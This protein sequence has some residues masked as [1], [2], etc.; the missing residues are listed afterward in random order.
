MATL[1]DG[2]VNLQRF[3]GLLASA[4]SATQQVGDHVKQA[5]QQFSRL[6]DEAEQEGGGLNDNLTEL[7]QTLERDEAEALSALGELLQAATDAQQAAG[8]AHDKVEQTATDLD[9]KAGT[10][11]TDL[12]QASGQLTSE[13]FQ[14]LGQLL[15]E[16]QQQID[17]ESNEEE[18]A[19]TELEG[20]VGTF[21]S[22]AET[23][24]N[25]AEQELDESTTDLTEAETEVKAEADES[26]QGFDTAAGEVETDCSNL[27]GAVDAMYDLMT[28]GV[29]TQGQAW[30][31]AVQTSAQEALTFTTDARQQRLDQP[32]AMVKD[33]AL[34]TLQQEYE[35]LDTVLEAAGTAVS[36]LEPLA[37]DL[38]KCQGAMAEIDALMDA[39]A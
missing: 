11:E 28:Q 16:A 25:D 31:Q 36:N 33:E 3:V 23:A 13:G 38:I 4:T 24:W 10:I 7:Q 35:A 14:P 34:T 30:Q 32:A 20:A 27:E 15:D 29:D 8:D 12:E 17:T 1:D 39:L 9:D 37:E 26:V 22:E 2:V 19:F 18:Q 5:S 21:E 6:E